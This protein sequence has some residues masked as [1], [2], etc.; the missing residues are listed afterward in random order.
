MITSTSSTGLASQKPKPAAQDSWTGQRGSLHG[1]CIRVLDRI[2]GPQ[3]LN[4]HPLNQTAAVLLASFGLAPVAGRA[5]ILAVALVCLENEYGDPADEDDNRAIFLDSLLMR[6]EAVQLAA[7]KE[8][9]PVLEPRTVEA[10]P[11]GVLA[12][13]VARQ[14]SER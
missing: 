14:L 1:A 9:E 11:P 3:R 7:V 8:L 5:N 2:L 13:L 4:D 12:D 10:L 6:S